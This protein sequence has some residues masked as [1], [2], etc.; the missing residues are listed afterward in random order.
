MEERDLAIVTGAAS[1]IGRAT[2]EVFARKGCDVAIMD[3]D[4]AVEEVAAAARAAGVSCH[5]ARG[6]VAEEKD[7][8]AFVSEVL[9]RFG[10]IDVLVNNAGVVL[11]RPVEEI[12]VE[13]FRRVVDVNLGGTFLFCKHVIPVM[14]RRGSGSIVNMG[15]VSGHVGQVDHSVYGATKGAIIA[16][17]RALA[18][19]VAPYG[20]RANS[21]SPGSV[22]TPM[23]RG[24]IEIESRKTGLPYE[25]VKKIREAEQA[26]RRWA[27]PQEIAEAVYF[28]ASE[29]ASFIT[30][31]DL[32]VDCGWVAK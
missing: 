3:I 31:T 29:K 25:E 20:I 1:G 21:L 28:L 27:S 11:V 2:A 26:F 30:G 19:E 9:E 8:E 16:F 12:A 17:T 5:H 22:D 23:L 13:D 32:L 15:S 7:V 14:K 4:N 18:W 10:R 24:D 6:D